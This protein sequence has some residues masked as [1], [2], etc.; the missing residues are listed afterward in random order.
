MDIVIWKSKVIW[1]FSGVQD[2]SSTKNTYFGALPDSV[3]FFTHGKYAILV[4]A[5]KHFERKNVTHWFFQADS[6]VF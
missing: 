4:E 2:V 6:D 5:E 3:R 1:T